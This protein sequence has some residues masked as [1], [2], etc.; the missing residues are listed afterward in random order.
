MEL[1]ENVFDIFMTKRIFGSIMVIII[2]SIIVS[3]LNRII[4]KLLIIGRTQKEIKK[5]R[6]IVKLFQNFCKCFIW[7]IAFLTI[8]DFWGVNT[9]SLIASLGVAGA[10]LG[11]ALQDTVKDIICGITLI[12]ENYFAVGDIVTFNDFTGEVVE[13]SIR[14]T[15]IKA[16]DGEVLVI[17]N[18]N[19]DSIKN[20]SQQEAN[21]LL[22]IDTAYEEKVEKVEKVLKEVIE[23]AIK[24]NLISKESEYLGVNELDSSSVKYLIK[25]ICN[26]N[27]RYIIRREMLKRV[28]LA[29]EANNIKIPYPQIEVHNGQKI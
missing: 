10:V 17:S 21:L 18:R 12:L 22:D 13:L 27:D 14:T 7:L 5:R 24:E 20:V 28:K 16:F 8:L 9:K 29:Y 19:I 26:Q 2:S 3:L 4:S 23:Q 15:K 1:L 25:I 6:T 11:L